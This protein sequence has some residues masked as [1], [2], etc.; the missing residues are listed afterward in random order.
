MDNAARRLGKNLAA[1]ETAS[2]HCQPLKKLGDDEV[3]V[4]LKH[5]GMSL[6]ITLC[7]S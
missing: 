2:D 4:D 5:S 7:D 6:Q 3:K 1:L